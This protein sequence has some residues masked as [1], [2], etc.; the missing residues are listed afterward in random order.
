MFPLTLL[1]LIEAK[2]RLLLPKARIMETWANN[3]HFLSWRDYLQNSCSQAGK[4][5]SSS[6][7]HSLAVV[8]FALA[9][10]ASTSAETA[11]SVFM[12]I[13]EKGVLFTDSTSLSRVRPEFL[14]DGPGEIGVSR[15]ISELSHS[16]RTQPFFWAS[17]IPFSFKVFPPHTHTSNSPST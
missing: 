14:G 13:L 16:W 2:W 12:G 8:T 6:V 1:K 4:L 9:I 15:V 10:S 17:S 5:L 7:S 3:T 11:F